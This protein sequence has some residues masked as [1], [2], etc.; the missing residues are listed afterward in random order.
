MMP[1]SELLACYARTGSEDCFAA[2]V[3]RHVNLV[4]STALRRVQ[5][6]THLAQDAAQSVFADLARKASSLSRRRSLTGWLYT[7]AHFAAAKLLRGENR[8]RAREQ[9]AHTM[10]DAD[11]NAASQTAWEN[12]EPVLDEI[13]HELDEFDRE[14][15]LLRY[16]ENR[17]FAELGT[18]LGLSENAA[19]MR[20][21][22]ALEKL[23][24][25]FARR[26]VTTTAA[27]ASAISANAVQ[28]APAGLTPTLT[29]TSLSGAAATFTPRNFMTLTRF[30]LGLGALALVGAA[31]TVLIQHQALQRATATNASL[32]QQV[33]SLEA[34]NADLSNRLD[35]AV[36][37]KSSRKD[38]IA[39]LLRL[40]AEVTRLR[41]QKRVELVITPP[42]TN[43]PPTAQKM[44]INVKTKF[45]SIPTEAL[46]VM[47]VVWTSAAQGGRTG[48]LTEQ[49]FKTI[50]EALQGASDVTLISAPQITTFNGGQAVV[51]TT[52][53]LPVQGTNAN[54]GVTLNLTPAFSTNSLTFN[55]NLAACLTE[56]TGDSSRPGLQTTQLTN[57]LSLQIGQTAVMEQGIPAGGWLPD[58][59]NTPAGPRS[60]LVFVT[61]RVVDSRGQPKYP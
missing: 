8:R 5:G 25:G 37:P 16:F 14:A 23:R 43:S 4:Y 31:A 38:Q 44:V 47:G 24:A 59:T 52:H 35:A 30:K 22:R 60:L 28:C 29:A 26:G 40:R 50:N 17:P 45:V 54:I 20:V 6:D 56:L 49:Q 58:Q 27:L 3:R 51:S 7:S 13:M 11:P 36:D 9:E 61:P 57:Q 34:D 12:V 46:Q 48:L 55:L 18:K 42:P 32:R 2:L 15:V 19:R 10:R 41:T 1:D 39:E 53:S 33:A 21:E